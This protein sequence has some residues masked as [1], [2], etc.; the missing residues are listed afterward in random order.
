MGSTADSVTLVDVSMKDQVHHIMVLEDPD[1]QVKETVRTDLLPEKLMSEL[2]AFSGDGRGKVT[3]GA[4][5]ASNVKFFKA[6]AFVSL[7]ITCDSNIDV[8][9]QVH[10]IVQPVV[11]GMVEEDHARMSNLRADIMRQ[12]TGESAVKIIAGEPPSLPVVADPSVAPGRVV[13][14]P[15]RVAGGYR[16]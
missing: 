11:Q 6:G 15:P 12:L 8:M 1:H 9:K 16:R 14:V 4:D 3:V 2:D 5:L 10:T 7:S 13:A